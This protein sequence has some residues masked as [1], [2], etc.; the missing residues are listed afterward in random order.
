MQW[1]R[2]VCLESN[3][4]RVWCCGLKNRFENPVTTFPGK[5]RINADLF[6]DKRAALYL[7]KVARKIRAKEKRVKS[8][9][10]TNNIRWELETIMTAC[11]EVTWSKWEYKCDCQSRLKTSICLNI[12]RLEVG[13]DSARRVPPSGGPEGTSTFSDLIFRKPDYRDRPGIP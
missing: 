7:Q 4:L 13:L 12:E 2:Y 10:S 11:L 8:W 1:I 9:A 5:R 6:I 3:Q